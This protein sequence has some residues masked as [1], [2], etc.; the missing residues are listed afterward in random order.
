M[1]TWLRHRLLVLRA[2][3]RKPPHVHRWYQRLYA[4]QV[5]CAGCD[6]VVT[7]TRLLS[8]SSRQT[9]VVWP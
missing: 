8:Q 9:R 4:E 7:D 1:R 3:E 6:C 2:E 5:E